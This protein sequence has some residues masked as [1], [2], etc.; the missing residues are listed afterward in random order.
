MLAMLVPILKNKTGDIASI[1]N[2]R[3]ITLATVYCKIMETCLV[4][5]LES[6]LYTN[7]NQF[8]YKICVYIC[9]QEGTLN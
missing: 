6:F 1:G 2:Y 9:I 8:S 3:P 4:S 7:D 5:R